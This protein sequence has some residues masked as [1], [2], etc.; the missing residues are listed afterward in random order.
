M[1]TEFFNI[2]TVLARTQ[3]IT[4]ASE[5]LGMSPSAVGNALA[6]AERELGKKLF[7]RKSSHLQINPDGV[8]FL[9]YVKRMIRYIDSIPDSLSESATQKGRIRIGVSVDTDTLHIVLSEFQK[10]YPDIRIDLSEH[11]A[12]PSN[13][14][15]TTDLDMAVI[16]YTDRVPENSITIGTWNQ[17]F[18]LMNGSHHLAGKGSLTFEDLAAESFVFSVSG[19]EDRH[20]EWVYSF[21]LEH[22]FE[23]RIAY[24]CDGF[25]GKLDIVAHTEALA[26]AYNTMRRFRER[27]NGIVSV[28]I[29]GIDSFEE[30]IY[31][32][33]RQEQLN[34]LTSVLVDFLK[35]FSEKGRDYYL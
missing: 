4:L 34:P 5:E 33:W 2:F 12:I 10:L 15:Q 35:E 22:G 20:V 24:L 32:T 9:D 19:D 28:P 21:C 26:V 30:N 25:D 16:Y 3:N 7:D 8:Y 6:K 13:W 31:L 17:L 27:L 14:Q 11:S 1:D 23:P 18:V 29:T